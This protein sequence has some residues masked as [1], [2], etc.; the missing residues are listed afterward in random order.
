MLRRTGRWCSGSGG[1]GRSSAPGSS[2]RP[3]RSP[4]A[5]WDAPRRLRSGRRCPAARGGSKLSL[6]HI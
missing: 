6:I 3:R 2:G 1:A 4:S 5:P